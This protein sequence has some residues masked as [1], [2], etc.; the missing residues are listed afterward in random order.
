MTWRSTALASGVTV[1]GMWVASYAPAGRPAVTASPPSPAAT[2][3]A[4]AAI[5]R[6]ARRLHDRLEHVGSYR[7]PSRN[8]FSFV[9]R[10]APAAREAAPAPIVEEPSVDAIPGPPTFRMSLAGL[11]EDTVDGALVRTAV[12]STPDTVLLAK[13]GDVVGGRYRVVSIDAASVDL[14]RVDD[15][16][17]VR[18]SLRP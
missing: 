9:P 17:I 15:G 7:Q 8:P 1:A 13:I 14:A 10:R 3:A 12:I 6:E 5:Q 16:T 2:E 4:S 18:L 11:A